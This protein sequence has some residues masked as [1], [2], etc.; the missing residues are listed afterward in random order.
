MILRE[1]GGVAALVCAVD[2][3]PLPVP[4]G[5]PTGDTVVNRQWV[6]LSLVS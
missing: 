6:L 4:R 1:T 2:D 5:G 3:T